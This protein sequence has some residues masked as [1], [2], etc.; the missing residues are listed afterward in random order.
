[1]NT[2][3]GLIWRVYSISRFEQ[4]DGGV[5]VELEA[6][7]LS[8]DV[9]AGLRWAVDPIVRRTSRGSIQVSLQKTREAVVQMGRAMD[10]SENATAASPWVLLHD[11]PAARIQSGLLP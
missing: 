7:A 2:G 3:R 6:I 5:Y 10:R 8:R 9:P 4:R 1:M 11:I